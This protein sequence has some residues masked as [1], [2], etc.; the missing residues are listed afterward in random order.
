M[1]CFYVNF[2]SLWTSLLLIKKLLRVYWV[3]REKTRKTP[4]RRMDNEKTI[5]L[6][7]GILVLLLTSTLTDYAYGDGGYHGGRG[8]YYGEVT[9]MEVAALSGRSLLWRWPLL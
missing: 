1:F 8:G 5:Y 2:R 7:I 4:L 9:I 3:V 6:I